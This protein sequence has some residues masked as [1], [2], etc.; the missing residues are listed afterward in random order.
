ML[1]A[2]KKHKAAFTYKSHVYCPLKSILK[3][4]GEKLKFRTLIPPIFFD[5]HEFISSP[6]LKKKSSKGK[7]IKKSKYV[8]SD[9]FWFLFDKETTPGDFTKKKNHSFH[10]L[11]YVKFN[12]P[13]SLF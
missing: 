10:H 3:N 8:V 4:P 1:L 11:K 6:N 13:L 2:V 12:V 5:T 9:L 7:T